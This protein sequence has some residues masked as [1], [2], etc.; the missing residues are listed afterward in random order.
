MKK[1]FLCFMFCF[2]FVF[3]TRAQVGIPDS[4]AGWFLEQNERVKEYTTQMITV[5]AEISN[6]KTQITTLTKLDG[7]H[8]KEIEQLKVALGEKQQQEGILQEQVKRYLKEIAKL[9]RRLKLGAIIGGI[10]LFLILLF[11]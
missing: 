2:M 3:P 5:R 6:L 4:V 10:L 1:L 8:V 7:D 11:K 9:Q